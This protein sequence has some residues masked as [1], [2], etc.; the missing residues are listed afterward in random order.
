MLSKSPAQPDVISDRKHHHHSS[1]TI[2]HTSHT[3]PPS[4]TNKAAVPPYTSFTV[5]A[6][7]PDLP[8]LSVELSEAPFKHKSVNGYD[9]NTT[10]SDMSYERLEFLGDAYIELIASR[11]IFH[12]FPQLTAGAQSQIRELLVKNETLAQFA[13]A[14]GFD[15]R[16]D[17]ADKQRL[18]ME[19]QDR[20]NKGF[21]KILGDC[22]EAYVAAAILADDE[23]GFAVVEKWLTALWTPKLLEGMKAHKH[24]TLSLIQDTSIDPSKVYSP[25][26]KAS[27]QRM[28]FSDEAKLEYQPYRESEELKGAQ[29]GQNRHY[30]A[31]YLTGYG[32]SRKLLGKGEG[33]NR[34]EAGNWAAIQAMHGEHKDLVEDCAQQL[35]AQREARKKKLKTDS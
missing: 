3:L 12:H 26:A 4:T 33:K 27:L 22:F 29:L 14:Y 9:R 21:N 18:K 31:V 6:G 24:E 23:H 13:K 28:L 34:V 7:L 10:A 11:L 1:A 2:A 19:A 16:L 15:Q 20:G 35:T 8:R 30:I 5:P 25:T 17:L 32:Y